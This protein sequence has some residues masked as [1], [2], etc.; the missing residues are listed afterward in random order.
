[1]ARIRTIKPD[2]FKDE[3]ISEM[4][5][6]T[7]LLF[8]GLWTLADREGRIADRPKRIKAEI[9]PYDKVDIEKCLN[10]LSKVGFIHRYEA[11][12][13]NVIQIKSFLRHQIPGRDEPQSELP[14]PDGS[15]NEYI[16]PPNETVRNRIYQRDN[17]ICAYCN[18]DLSNKS[19]SRC[20]DHVIP[21]SKGGSN[22][23]SNLVTS[24]KR[25]N[26]QKG[27]RTPEEAGMKHPVNPPLTDNYLPVNG[28]VSGKEKEGERKG[29]GRGIRNG[30]SPPDGVFEKLD[31]KIPFSESFTDHWIKWKDFKK[32]E[33]RFFF[34]SVH[35]EQEAL[36]VLVKLSDGIEE[37][38]IDIIQQS[39]ANGWK[40]LFAL[41][42]EHGK[43]KNGS[44][45][46]SE[47]LGRSERNDIA[48]ANY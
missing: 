43:G 15:K 44:P 48:R 18:E 29:K 45:G 12:E 27:C 7:R 33:H 20:L 14:A 38:A 11:Q 22:H 17:Y 13:T 28:F 46:S 31:L 9:F 4:P 19:R 26:M 6:V 23:E 1:M 37:T 47:K 41:K 21:Y 30:A 36:N 32:K 24:C 40:G 16:K 3:E 2:F 35:S 25:C 10:D 5:V 34:K 39:I 42:H 8:I